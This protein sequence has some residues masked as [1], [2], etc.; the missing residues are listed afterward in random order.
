MLKAKLLSGF[1]VEEISFRRACFMPEQ[2]SD[3]RVI[4]EY[5]EGRECERVFHDL[6][7]VDIRDYS[8]SFSILWAGRG[9]ERHSAGTNVVFRIANN[10][11]QSFLVE[12]DIDID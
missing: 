11:Q 1:G 5:A 7:E 2:G 3:F 10:C 8:K 4:Y 9:V 12:N 6:I